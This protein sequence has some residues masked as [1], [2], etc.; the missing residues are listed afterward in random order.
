[1][2]AKLKSMT[3]PYSTALRDALIG[4]FQWEIL[5]SIENG[6][7]AASRGEQTH[8]G[9][10]AYRA[11]CCIGQVLF[12][13]NKRY[14]INEKGAMEEAARLPQTLSALPERAAE[15]WAAIGGCA[16]GLAF[17]AL[18]VCEQELRGLTKAR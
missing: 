15:I 14:L 5:F 10:C 13:V 9:G 12:A 6:E 8:I 18:R 11:L 7:I 2:I 3:S 4:Q 16:Y 17:K 1:M